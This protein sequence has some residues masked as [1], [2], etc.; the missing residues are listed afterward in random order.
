MEEARAVIEKIIQDRLNRTVFNTLEEVYLVGGFVRDAFLKRNS[1]D[2]DYAVRG[3]AA[4]KAFKIRRYTG[5]TIVKLKDG[6]T[7]RIALANGN[8]LDFTGYEEGID[9]DL[10]RRDFT[11]NAIAFSEARGI[12]DP[13]GGTADLKESR[14]RMI[15][16]EN[17]K[18]DPV[19]VVRAYRFV[20][21]L[22]GWIDRE[23]RE[24]IRR[25]KG[26]LRHAAR[27]RITLEFFRLLESEACLR[28]LGE[29]YEDSVGGEIIPLSNSELVMTMKKLLEVERKLKVPRE[30]L[31]KQLGETVSQGL[32][33]KGLLRLDILLD[34]TRIEDTRLRLSRKLK[35]RIR[36]FST[37]GDLS[38]CPVTDRECLFDLFASLGESITEIL[39][40]EGRE[41]LL[42]EAGRYLETC[43]NP[44]LSGEDLKAIFGLT[45]GPRIGRLL[46]ELKRAQYAGRFSDRQG[47]VW[48]IERLLGKASREP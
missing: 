33:L 40:A 32:T 5:G 34:R 17:L 6:L 9:E 23:T 36:E 14:V 46:L 42:G 48:F 29:A 38:G 3:D 22:D 8:T 15:R 37:R 11:F 47:A 7:V 41:E 20:G 43:M 30:D 24:A 25:C 13:L 12:H 35:A 31:R 16:E 4:E 27:E 28:A 45:E 19:R 2:R 18:E 10:L 1:R 26:R 39:I 21:E 44:V